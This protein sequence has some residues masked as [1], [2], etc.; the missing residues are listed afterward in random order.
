MMR[1]ELVAILPGEGPPTPPE[2]CTVVR[3]A[4]HAAVLRWSGLLPAPRKADALRAA[5]AR[6]R[7]LET[8]MT[9]GTVLPVLPGQR[10][11]ASEA[12]R[13]VTANLPVLERLASQ[14]AGRRQFQITL[15]WDVTR[16]VAR[17]GASEGAA[18]AD[19]A[20]PAIAARL[21]ERVAQA[22]EDTGAEVMMLP[23]AEDVVANAVV[24]VD[25]ASEPLLDAALAEIDGLWTEG[26]RIRMIG[27]YPPV[28]FASLVFDRMDRRQIEEAQAAFGLDPGFS[29]TA[30]RQARREVIM[31]AGA[32][33]H[34]ALRRQADLL[35][36]VAR[37]GGACARVH[38]ARVWS[39]GLSS[40]TAARARAA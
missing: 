3:A 1:R 37:L 10:I 15:R 35:A 11:R 16:A 6:A 34:E 26:F 20:G 38:V 4:K 2:G 24:L 28:S 29:E 12:E 23:V 21:R 19:A 22:L 32:D 5:A 30:L 18:A 27:P 17:F 40:A 7:I 9:S 25:A 39:E 13:L 31:Q 33:R 14:F 8:L 36:C